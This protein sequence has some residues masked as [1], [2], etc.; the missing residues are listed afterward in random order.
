VYEGV[1][2]HSADIFGLNV[3]AAPIDG[4][5]DVATLDTARDCP[6][7]GPAASGSAGNWSGRVEA[8]EGAVVLPEREIPIE[9]VLVAGGG[10]GE[11]RVRLHG[12]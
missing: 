11:H 2:T 12:G 6:R 3:W 1:V 9:N 8:Y 7:I 5:V 10:E 4:E